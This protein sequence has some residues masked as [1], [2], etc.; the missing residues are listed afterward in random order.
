MMS[1]HTYDSEDGAGPIQYASSAC[2]SASSLIGGYT[3]VPS[4]RAYS[5][6]QPPSK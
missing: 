4:E 2:M 5:P 1:R 6:Y 3:D